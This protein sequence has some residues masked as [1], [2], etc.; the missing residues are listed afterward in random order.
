[1]FFFASTLNLSRSTDNSSHPWL[2]GTSYSSSCPSPSSPFST[3][4]PAAMLLRS[5]PGLCPTCTHSHRWP[6]KGLCTQPWLWQLR[7]FWLYV[8]LTGIIWHLEIFIEKYMQQI[9][10]NTKQLKFLY[11]WVVL[12]SVRE[13]TPPHHTGDHYN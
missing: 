9:N 12:V 1:M 6:S 5:S 11:V 10:N 8:N 13:T 4:S 3:S 2:C 7:G